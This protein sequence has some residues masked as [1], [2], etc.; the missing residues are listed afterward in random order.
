MTLAL[1][2]S[3]FISCSSAGLWADSQTNPAATAQAST[4]GAADKSS[5]SPTQA[6]DQTA[7]PNKPAAA[8]SPKRKKKP[9]PA[10][11]CDSNPGKAGDR[12]PASGGSSS[13]DP[14]TSA[15]TTG[16][17]TSTAN[18]P[19]NCP[20]AKIIV[21]D[22]G[23]SEPAVQLTGGAG[24]GGP[25]SP[26]N[27]TTDQLLGATEENLKKLPARQ[28]TAD[29]QAM[30]NQIHQYM[31]QSKAATAEGDVERGHSLAMKANL[32]SKDLTKP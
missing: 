9:A 4:P 25:A 22:G 28:L 3:V 31:E 24:A 10:A 12:Q 30:V 19:T 17:S 16:A 20:P 29:Q 2:L 7:H 21:R 8:K 18:K 1:V 27:V 5:A 15:N 13:A 23:T 32:L 11:N 14:S 6:T 26:Q